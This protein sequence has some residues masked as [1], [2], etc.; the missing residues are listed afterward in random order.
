M[1]S[2]KKEL[3]AL[4]DSQKL[5]QQSVASVPRSQLWLTLTCAVVDP[6]V[7]HAARLKERLS[8]VGAATFSQSMSQSELRVY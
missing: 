7:T 2:F 1:T 4:L 5:L 8:G 6:L 3:A